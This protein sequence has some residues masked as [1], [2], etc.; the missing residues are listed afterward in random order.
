MSTIYYDKKR[1]KDNY[2]RWKKNNPDSYKKSKSIRQIR[3]KN[4]GL[5]KYTEYKGSAKSRGI[6]FSLTIKEFESF[7]QKPCYYCGDTIEKIGLDRIDSQKGYFIGNV[8]P[9]CTR[10]NKAKNDMSVTEFLNWV[11]KVFNHI[12]DITK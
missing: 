6:D 2:D 10:C 7:W 11:I 9:C 8:T 1:Y 5:W 3:Y 4:T 12:T